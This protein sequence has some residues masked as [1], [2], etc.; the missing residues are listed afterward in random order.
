MEKKEGLNR[1][2]AKFEKPETTEPSQNTVCG[3]C[4]RPATQLVD[5]EP[6][7]ADHL[8]QVYEHQVED[9]TRK[10]LTNNAWREV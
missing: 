8:G 9:Y 2:R 4:G 3:L 6:C 10:H 5:G 7:C 1:E